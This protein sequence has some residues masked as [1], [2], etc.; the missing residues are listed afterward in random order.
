MI[1]PCS[2]EAVLKRTEHLDFQIPIVFM[3]FERELFG[4]PNPVFLF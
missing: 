3:I 2:Q 4:F 1:K